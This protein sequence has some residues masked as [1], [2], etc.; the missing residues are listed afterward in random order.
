MKAPTEREIA[1]PTGPLEVLFDAPEGEPRGVV[2]LGHPLPT[3]GGTM[4]TKMV[5]QAAKG[6]A[7]AGYLVLRFNFRGVGLSAG[8]FDN[9]PGEMD[10][11]RAAL[12]Y[13]AKAYPGLPLLA[14]GASYG[15]WVGMTVGAEDPRVSALIGIAPAIMLRDFA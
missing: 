10:D 15:S 14:G 3:Q 11:F 5:F 7:R 12:D 9:G 2:V 8:K 4:H 6:L 13:V 1:G